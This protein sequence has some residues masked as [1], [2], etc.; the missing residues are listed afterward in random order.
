MQGNR[1]NLESYTYPE[2][3]QYAKSWKA[4][5]RGMTTPGFSKLSLLR[6]NDKV[7]VFAISA[8]LNSSSQTLFTSTIPECVS[9]EEKLTGSIID[10][11]MKPAFQLDTLIRKP[12]A[13]SAEFALM[14]ERQRAQVVQGITDIDICH[15]EIALLAG[16]QLVRYN[17]ET[18][19]TVSVE[20]ETPN[21]PRNPPRN[22]VEPM[23]VSEGTPGPQNVTNNRADEA[24]GSKPKE[25]TPP[26]S[27][28]FI[29]SAKVCP[30]DSSLI[31]YVLNKEVY[32]QRNGQV[33]YNTTSESKHETNGVP[34]YIVQE[35]LERFEGIWWS[36]SKTR[37][38][39]EH[40]NEEMVEN[41]QFGINGQSPTSPMKYPRAGTTNSK[42]ELR[43]VVIEGD[44]VHDVGLKTELLQK[45]FPDYEYI[46]RAG[47]YTD[48]LTVWVQLM[49]REQSECVLLLVPFWEFDLPKVLRGTTPPNKELQ[50]SD[51]LNM[52][53]WDADSKNEVMEK[54][55]TG[56]L[57]TSVVIHKTRSEF[58]INTHNAIYPL[59][60]TNTENPTYEFIYC[61]E[62]PNGSCLSLISAELDQNGYC[63]HTAEKILMAETYSINK[64]IQIVV[65]EERELVY[66]VANESHPTEWN[67]CVSNYRNGKHKMLT[68]LGM[69]FKAERANGK[70]AL[71][72]QSGFACF[73]TALGMPSHC[74]F[75]TF[76]WTEGDELPEAVHSANIFI[77]GR[78]GCIDHHLDVPEMLEYTSKKTGFSHYALVIRPPNFDATKKY[79]VYQYVYG[80][81]GIQTVHN[82][83]SWIQFIRFTRLGYVVVLI[84]NR[85][86]ANRGITF[87]GNIT[88]KMGSV[89][90]EDQVEGIQILA[91][92]TGGFMDLSRVIVQG[93]SY[94]GY[95]ALQ[96]LAKHPKVYCAAI[97]GGA[98]SDWRLY[99]TAYTERYMGFPVM[100]V[101]YDASSVTPLVEKLPDEPNRLM[102][103]HGLMDENVHFSHLTTLVDECIKKGKW[104]ELVIFP[105]ERHGIRNTDASIYLD[106]RM[107]YFAQTAMQNALNALQNTAQGDSN[108]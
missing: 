101:V 96:M 23:D 39:Y 84:D 69:S 67:V 3:Y 81:P 1:A 42:S 66:F 43:M 97:A 108:N 6:Y 77:S 70:L 35:E 18:H 104:H 103:V 59:K 53:V 60:S 5:I 46:T 41:A 48:G 33:I 68:Q 107:M 102:L 24:S 86:S 57:V 52:G 63:R 13:P 79:P 9:N 26:P 36:E 17:A 58:W 76:K 92:R 28:N 27:N 25:A 45:H 2:F 47:F 61:L 31:A 71:D 85:G 75:Y 72:F 37:L 15:N 51:N 11:K 83:Y 38:L 88:R 19:E 49:N 20:V 89:E 73:M 105:H 8:G 100:D 30:A 10:I 95:M 14:C 34:S 74:R 21:D 98:V 54:P 106:A 44:K 40:V 7:H 65:D 16:D 55:P 99:D 82:D 93:W 22:V 32:I 87:E 50:L 78:E 4:E 56:G 80:G 91:E 64:T 62:K 90:V 29:S 94:G 12:A